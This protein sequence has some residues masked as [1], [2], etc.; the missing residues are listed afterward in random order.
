ME[1]LREKIFGW[2]LVGLLAITG[3]ALGI[4]T[5]G[6]G[7]ALIRD[8]KNDPK[9]EYSFCSSAIHIKEDI[10]AVVS[11]EGNT[12]TFTST[13]DI[14]EELEFRVYMDRGTQI[15]AE[16]DTIKKIELLFYN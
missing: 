5:I 11:N 2:I 3:V 14:P 12:F 13:E 10:Y 9:N 1:E 6:L 8:W 7:H 16:D 4:A 15:G